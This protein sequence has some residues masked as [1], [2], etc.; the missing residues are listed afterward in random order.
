MIR[1][2]LSTTAAAALLVTTLAPPAV[3]QVQRVEAVVVNSR[4]ITVAKDK[5]LAFRL[6]ADVGEL[7]VAQP[8]VAEIVAKT[9]RSFYIRGKA[10]GMTNILVYGPNQQLI[11]VIDVR[12]A[13]DS[14]A[15]RQDLAAA[16][17]GESIQV[18]HVADGLMLSGRVS[19]TAS[20]NRAINVAQ[21]Y[22][23]EQVSTNLQVASPDQVVLEVR[24]LEASRTALRDLGINL[25]VTGTDVQ[26]STGSGLIGVSPPAGQFNAQALLGNTQI[27][28]T[29]R[30]LEET[31]AVRTLA[32][33]NLVALSGEEA[34]FLAG[35][36]FPFPVPAG[37]QQVTIE[38]KP[39]GVELR[40]TPEV[41]D[42]GRIRL[43]VAPE[44]S[45]LDTQ[46]TI[47]VD[48]LE[49][50]GLSVRRASTTVELESG[51][52][53]AIAGLFQRDMLDS[54]RQVPGLGDVP[55]LG[56]LFRS[57]RWREQETE[58]VI[59]VTPRMADMSAPLRNPLED[60][61]FN[62]IPATPAPPPVAAVE[63]PPPLVA[64]EAPAPAIS[65][66]APAAET[67]RPVAAAPAPV[68]SPASAEAP[69][70]TAPRV[71]PGGPVVE[72][73][74]EFRAVPAPLVVPSVA[75]IDNLIDLIAREDGAAGGV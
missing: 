2:L 52:S 17:P 70:Q 5:S 42:N 62:R 7:V 12:V 25:A 45:Q 60:A 8:D 13:P 51:R 47:R 54:V 61:D 3:G 65:A 32:Q 48:G 23:G 39:F 22:A 14:E 43:K 18:S 34:S 6:N 64:A 63:A 28:L 72:H 29:L 30:A 73:V 75:S 20:M 37:P 57:K 26:V 50:P 4:A 33:P 11:E 41:R 74:A 40:F 46:R 9:D 53:F 35:G 69:V 56:A 71:P 15:L 31:G 67:V 36:E 68:T 24:I 19:T 66:P 16:L 59:I 44:V 58:L 1:K 49:V 27:D 21:R 55:I 10:F 38:F